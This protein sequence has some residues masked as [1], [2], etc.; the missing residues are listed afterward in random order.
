[1]SY[2]GFAMKKSLLLILAFILVF[3]CFAAL[4]AA[5]DESELYYI[6]VQILRIFPHKLGYY[7]IYRRAGLKTGEVFI[8]HE[9][10]DRR[11]SRAILSLVG[12]DVNPYLTF[13]LRNGEF[14]HIR[15]CAMKDLRHG[16]W[17]MISENAIEADRFQ[18]ETLN[19]QF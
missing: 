15:I 6:N 5:A 16:T 2:G 4:P 3:G 1:M 14:D 7:I 13:V 9:W 10:F 8:P 19:P 12:G 18:V 17:G 11:D